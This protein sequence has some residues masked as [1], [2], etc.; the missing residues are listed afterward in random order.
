VKRA[1]GTTPANSHP[2]C[3]RFLVFTDDITV[4]LWHIADVPLA[5]SNV[6]FEWENG[7]DA[8]VP[9]CQL[10]TQSGHAEIGADLLF[11]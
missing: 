6:C 11:G 4:R 5:L 10:L 9:L 8:I 2:S 3:E 1:P 7:H